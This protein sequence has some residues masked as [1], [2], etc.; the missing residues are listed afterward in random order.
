[1]HFLR[2]SLFGYHGSWPGAVA[3]SKPSLIAAVAAQLLCECQVTNL[4]ILHKFFFPLTAFPL[5]ENQGEPWPAA[6]RVKERKICLSSAKLQLW[7]LQRTG[8][9][10]ILDRLPASGLQACS[11]PKASAFALQ[12]NY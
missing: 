5:Y 10:A 12:T 4:R 6:R 2:E 9:L 3:S 8:L 7:Y 11:L 1:M